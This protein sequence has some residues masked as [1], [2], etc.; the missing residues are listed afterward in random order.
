MS[1]RR[2]TIRQMRIIYPVLTLVVVLSCLASFFYAR[3]YESRTLI[4][5]VA[6]MIM[7]F[8]LLNITVWMVTSKILKRLRQSKEFELQKQSM[9]NA[10]LISEKI[11]EH[12]EKIYKIHHDMKNHLSI[13]YSMLD[14]S[15]DRDALDYS[16]KLHNLLQDEV[17]IC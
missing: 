10:I 3:M 4:L 14:D 6:L 11:A 7:L 13:L 5:L 9:E 8:V 17:K 2:F 15:Q 1:S 12:E 16:Q